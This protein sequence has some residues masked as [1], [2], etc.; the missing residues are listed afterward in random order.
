MLVNELRFSLGP[1]EIQGLPV[2][3]VC[4]LLVCEMRCR[5]KLVYI[6]VDIESEEAS[7]LAASIQFYTTVSHALASCSAIAFGRDV[8]KS[9]A[10]ARGRSLPVALVLPRAR[11]F[12]CGACPLRPPLVLGYGQPSGKSATP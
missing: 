7:L 8:A 12:V 10:P 6:V 5:N 4:R 2:S 3:P 1:R 11:N 9:C